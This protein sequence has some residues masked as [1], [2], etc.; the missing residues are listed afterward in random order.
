VTLTAPTSGKASTPSGP[1]MYSPVSVVSPKTTMRS[2]SPAPSAGVGAVA[3]SGSRES[4]TSLAQ[5]VERRHNPTVRFLMNP[6]NI[7]GLSIVPRLDAPNIGAAQH[8]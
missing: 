3:L 4:G 6:F 7:S 2:R 5:A 1:T 8:N